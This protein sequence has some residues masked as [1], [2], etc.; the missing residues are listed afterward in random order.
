M[1]ENN[2]NE[3]FICPGQYM[4]NK[5]G[6]RVRVQQW[7][8]IIF[9]FGPQRSFSHINLNCF[10]MFLIANADLSYLIPESRLSSSLCLISKLSNQSLTIK[11]LAKPQNKIIF[12]DL[13]SVSTDV[14]C[15]MG[16]LE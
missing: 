8:K 16:A 1:A 11:M 15:I 9:Q 3:T 7:D 2:K 13:A 14:D 5:I 10:L 6:L 4:I 12:V